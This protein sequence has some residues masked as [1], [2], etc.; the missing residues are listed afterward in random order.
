MKVDL[1]IIEEAFK[2]GMPKKPMREDFSNDE[3]FEECYGY[4]MSH[5]GL[6]L[7]LRQKIR[8]SEASRDNQSN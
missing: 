1:D 3:A 5:Y 8:N 7:A 2:Q 6:I 4:W